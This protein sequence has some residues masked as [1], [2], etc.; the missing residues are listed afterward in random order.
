VPVPPGQS[1]KGVVLSDHLKSL[2]WHQ[3]KA[4]KAGRITASLLAQVRD[5]IAALLG[6]S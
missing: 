3:R 6:L 2:D 5:R 1:I 4:Q